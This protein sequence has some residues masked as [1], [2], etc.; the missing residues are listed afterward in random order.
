MQEGFYREFDRL[1]P[2]PKQSSTAPE[3]STQPPGSRKNRKQARREAR[4]VAQDAIKATDAKISERIALEKEALAAAL[5][6]R[7]DEASHRRQTRGI[8]ADSEREIK[9]LTRLGKSERQRLRKAGKRGALAEIRL[10]G[11]LSVERQGR[12][13]A[14]ATAEELVADTTLAVENKIAY[15]ANALEAAQQIS[16]GER[17][18]QHRRRVKQAEAG[19]ASETKR[20]RHLQRREIKRLRQAGRK[21]D[22][23]AIRIAEELRSEQAA[24]DAVEQDPELA[25]PEPNLPAPPSSGILAESVTRP[26]PPPPTTLSGARRR[27]LAVILGL[28]WAGLG[29]A[30]YLAWNQ[31]RLDDHLL[32]G[33]LAATGVGL[34]AFSLMPWRRI[35]SRGVATTLLLGFVLMLTA[36]MV[37]AASLTTSQPIRFSAFT[38]L[39]MSAALLLPSRAYVPLAAIALA[40][41]LP[42]SSFNGLREAAPSLAA[43]GV[44]G[45]LAGIFAFELRAQARRG[46]ADLQALRAQRD[47]LRDREVVLNRLYEISRT[48]GAGQDLGEVLPELVGRAAGYVNARVGLVLLYQPKTEGLEVQSPIWVAGQALEAEGYTFNL[49]DRSTAVRVFLQGRPV[50]SNH[51]DGDTEVVDAFLKD[52]GVHRMAAVP[53]AVEG[54][55]VGVLMV[56][57][58]AVEFTEE[59]IA[60]LQTVAGPAAMVLDHLSRYEDA[61]ETS[62]RMEELARMKSDFVSTV[63]HELRTPLTSV[64]GSLATLARP[65]LAPPDLKAQKLIASA[66]TQANRLNRLIEDL[67]ILSR[68]E[69]RAL[70]SQPE[71]VDI[72]ELIAETIAGLQEWQGLT[73]RVE[74]APNLPSVLVDPEH[75]RRITINLLDNARK[76][77]GRSAI[78]VSA[79]Q[80]VD[81]VRISVSDHGPGV[82]FHEADHIFER[83]TQLRRDEAAGGAGLG[84]AIVKELV[85]SM[86]GKVW[87]EPTVDGGATFVI[88]L[89][90]SLTQKSPRPSAV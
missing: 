80:I 8:R 1:R 81:E 34:L 36:G 35:A 5:T 47:E 20:L 3:V 24:W 32:A 44:M 61:Q 68:L 28:A 59:D 75:F 55:P 33:A 66:Q 26:S 18:R 39:V 70:H 27:S 50:F 9:R 65:E 22:W 58:K 79:L 2:A 40:A 82:P 48:I 42:A 83:F 73:I 49:R 15:L 10:A 51:L 30:A 85:E 31:H 46:D 60:S 25:I 38:L 37:A 72:G 12:P 56:A 52:L 17:R 16:D 43:L 69:S 63:S 74:V 64:I 23:E 4:A 57:D 76:Y 71:V 41:Y 45:V 11:E 7:P 54:R 87:Y 90:V 78:E 21:G 6:P 67:L 13:N 62:R 84:L 19:F 29:G 89:P 14:G 86:Q 88:A 77:A 53:L